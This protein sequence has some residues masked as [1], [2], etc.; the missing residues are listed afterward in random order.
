MKEQIKSQYNSSWYLFKRLFV[1]YISSLKKKLCL[2]FFFMIITACAT[3]LGAWIIQPVLDY[4]FIN[5]NYNMLYIIP[6]I[7]VLKSILNGVASFYE[8]ILIKRVGQ[9]IVANIQIEL[10]DHL[11]HADLKFLLKY[12]SGNLISRFTND[13]N[14]LKNATSEI[15]AG[16]IKE[17]FTLLALI[18]VM[19]YQSFTLTLIVI[20]IFPLSFYPVIKLGKKMKMISKNMQEKLGDFTVRLDETFQNIK[21]K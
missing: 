7:I 9:Q 13:I 10:Y 12:P 19:F 20:V 5:K 4:I 2:A 6:F 15:F 21:V 3:A 1:K 17:F 11:I 8:S 18:G 16:I 14:V